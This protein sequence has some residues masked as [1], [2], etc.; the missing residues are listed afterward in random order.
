MTE[1][2][3]LVEAINVSRRMGIII[4][5]FTG[6]LCSVLGSAFVITRWFTKCH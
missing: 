6:S 3:R 1:I 4:G 2:E 5:F